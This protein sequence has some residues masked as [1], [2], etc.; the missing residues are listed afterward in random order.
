MARS[1]TSSLLTAAQSLRAA[2]VATLTPARSARAWTELY[3]DSSSPTFSD[4][5]WLNSK[6]HR[7]R[8]TAGN[9]EY[10][11]IAS[12][13]TGS[14]WATWTT[15]LSTARTDSDVAMACY[16]NQ[17]RIYYT[18]AADDDLYMLRSDD[19]G[20]TWLGPTFVGNV[21]GQSFLAADGYRV[22]TQT[23]T[24][25]AWNVYSWSSISD[26]GD[27]YTGI[28]LPYGIAFAQ[29]P[30]AGTEGRIVFAHNQV[31]RTQRIN[32]GLVSGSV[33]TLAPGGDQAAPDDASPRY[34]S[35]AALGSNRWA[36]SY[37]DRYS[38]TPSWAR[39]IV[40]YNYDLVTECYHFGA[41]CALDTDYSLWQRMALAW[42]SSAK[43][44]YA[45]NDRAVHRTDVYETDDTDG[46]A[47]A[48]D[49]LEYTRT[50]RE[51]E[52]G[53][54]SATFV[55]PTGAHRP[56]ATAGFAFAEG[57]L[58]PLSSVLIARGWITS[59]GPETIALD[60][61][62]ITRTT[63]SEYQGAGL[64]TVE[65]VDG[66]GLLEMHTPREPLTF[67][68]RSLRWL[69][70]EICALAGLAWS[71]D[72]D[73]IWS[74][75]CTPYTLRPGR[76]LRAHLLDLLQTAGAVARCAEDG[77]IA[78]H[79][80]DTHAPGSVPALGDQGEILSAGFALAA[81]GATSIAAIGDAVAVHAESP[82]LAMLQG[83]SFHETAPDWR[84]LNST[85]AT[86]LADY[87]MAR[88][89][90]A[91]TRHELTLM[92]RPELEPWDEV[93]VYAHVDN[94]PASDR[95]KT[96]TAIE[97]QWRGLRARFT[98]RLTLAGA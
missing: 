55:D 34:P 97:E 45:G 71:D 33:R 76:S 77:T 79:V 91:G 81:H 74:Q 8:S 18:N 30:D 23:T 80:L 41:E 7:A 56:H 64:V 36:I 16:G 83:R 87:A 6:L 19:D 51:H 89:A 5:V 53:I 78:A 82:A 4:H 75:T 88:A 22:L 93:D 12:P 69:A 46:H 73:A 94:V 20:A 32:S 52:P 42:D 11:A 58:A 28:T 14:D 15:L 85:L 10:Q 95:R 44:L 13:G 47:D 38:G 17:L 3:T 27:L 29:Q 92:L 54:L 21:S 1:I 67:T 40:R 66:F 24:I 98:S 31:I 62:Y 63:R 61:H 37:V 59:A 2:P 35:I 9:I 84:I 50:K 65:A 49:L 57:Q 90:I 39:P 60:P 68:N 25:H 86:Q 26:R 72:A 48:V 70:L 43:R 96:I